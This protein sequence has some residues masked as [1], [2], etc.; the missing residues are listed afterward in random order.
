MKTKCTS[1]TSIDIETDKKF[2]KRNP[3]LI[4]ILLA[5]LTCCVINSNAQ[6]TQFG[7]GAF[8]HNITGNYNTAIGYQ[9][10]YSNTAGSYN[11]AVG[12]QSMY[13]NTT[14][15]FNSAHGFQ[16]LFSNIS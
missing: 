10:L 5:V 2:K 12:Y 8:S 16:S 6:N 3:L 11:S 15:R 7:S 1:A 13:S 9:T 4:A 14:G